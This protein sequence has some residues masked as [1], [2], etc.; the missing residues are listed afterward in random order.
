M[1]SLPLLLTCLGLSAFVCSQE[2]KDVDTAKEVTGFYLGGFGGVGFVEITSTQKGAAL[3]SDYKPSYMGSI[4]VN[5]S[6]TS[7]NH[8]LGLGGL[9]FGYEWYKTSD[10]K[11][12]LS[13]GVECETFY[14]AQEQEVFLDNPYSVSSGVDLHHFE[15][16][17]PTRNWGFLVNFVLSLENPYLTPYV[18]A[19]FGHKIIWIHDAYADQI[20]PAEPGINHFNGKTHAHD[21]VCAAQF[22]GGIRRAFWKHYR[23]FAEYRLLYNAKANFELGPAEYPITVHR[24]TTLW[25]VGF[26]STYYN[27]VVFGVDFMW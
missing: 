21:W 5:A 15:D 22:K 16:S 25:Q 1:R 10:K 12:W 8:C 4:D 14:F 19:G 17:F 11:V 9:H 7:S 27:T 18:S 3:Y 6:G 23:F 24:P 13:P 2:P 20:E 26:D